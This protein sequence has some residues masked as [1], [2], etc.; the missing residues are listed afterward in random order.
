[1]AEEI[2]VGGVET[3]MNVDA[4]VGLARACPAIFDAGD[5]VAIEVDGTFGASSFA[6]HFCVVDGDRE[7]EH[8]GCEEPPCGEGIAM[9]REPGCDQCC[10]DDEQAKI[11]KAEMQL[12]KVRNLYLAGLLTLF[13]LLGRG[14]GGGMHKNIIAYS[15]DRFI[16]CAMLRVK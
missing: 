5:A 3:G 11:S 15:S 14:G 4:S 13:V 7:K 12:F 9:E 2:E 16:V 6:Q 1:M 10:D 8:K